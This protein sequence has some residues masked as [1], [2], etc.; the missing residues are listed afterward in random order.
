[1]QYYPLTDGYGYL[2]YNSSDDKTIIR[3]LTVRP[4]E[5]GE[6]PYIK[7]TSVSLQVIVTPSPYNVAVV[8]Q[9]DA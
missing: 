4:G 9:D 1:M 7:S 5:G 6:N 3:D 8:L 2:V